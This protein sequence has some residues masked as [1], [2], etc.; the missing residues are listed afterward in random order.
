MVCRNRISIITGGPGTGKT[1]V[2]RS[3]I[4]QLRHLDILQACPTGKAAK[5]L[6]EQT[7]RPA[8]TI[9]RLLK[10]S[11]TLHGFEYNAH[12]PLPADLLIVDETSMLDIELMYAL[13]AAS[14]RSKIVF[15][16]DVDQ[17]PSVGPG[18]VLQDMIQSAVIPVTRLTQIFRQGEGS[19]ICRAA[20][21]I[22]SGRV[23]GAAAD[24][25]LITLED[26]QH[27][28]AQL[29]DLA[30]LTLP[31][32]GVPREEIQVLCPQRQGPLGAEPLNLQLQA[33][34]N[35]AEEGEAVWKTPWGDLRVDDRVMQL[36]NNY[37]L[38]V[39]NGEVGKVARILPATPKTFQAPAKPQRL[40]VDYSDREVEYTH[41]ERGEI[42]LAY[43][44]TVHKALGDEYQAV[45]VAVHTAN[46]IMLTRKLFYTAITRGKQACYVVGNARGRQRAVSQKKV[47]TR[48][49]ALEERLRAPTAQEE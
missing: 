15:V 49:S 47:V 25:H 48:Y 39:F 23:P 18:A 40:V 21:D 22:L 2:C 27:V 8:Q 46:D 5:R 17:L 26:P 43:A 29:V 45:V 10:W 12:N 4:A 41:G 20:Q 30:N 14:A 33:A 19:G 37:D 42:A 44:C 13:L 38:G 6:A 31:A 32:Q 36:R 7:G 34:S 1:T 11:P 9:H 35:P 3:V 16:G 24:F 28:A